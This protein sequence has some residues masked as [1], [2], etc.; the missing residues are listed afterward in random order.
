MSTIVLIRHGETDLAGRFC[1]YSDPRLN[2]SGERD[3]IRVAEEISRLDISCIYSSDLH[4]AAQ[5]ARAIA[6]QTGITVEYLRE[7]REIHFGRWEG[8]SW[9]EIETRFADEAHRWLREFL[10]QSAPGG[11]TYTDFTT[12]VETAI[13]PLLRGAPE[14]MIAV[15]THRGVMRHVLTEL[16]GFAETEAS[17]RTAV[18]GATVIA[19]SPQSRCEEQP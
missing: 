1:G 8:L 15:V 12:R 5:T 19:A 18:Y 6:K 9:N 4:R 3:A 16:F 11:E 14:M 13:A 17:T 7:L 10:F 2:A